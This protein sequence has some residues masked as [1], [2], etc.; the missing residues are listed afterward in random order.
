[1]WNIG[2]WELMIILV[3]VMLLFGAKRLPEMGKSLGS[4]IRE[5]KKSISAIDEDVDEKPA[6]SEKI[7]DSRDK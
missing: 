4:G 1:M 6:R 2:P 5:F 7:E 3:I